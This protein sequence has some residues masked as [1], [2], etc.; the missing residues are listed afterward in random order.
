MAFF[1]NGKGALEGGMSSSRAKFPAGHA[2]RSLVF[3][4]FCASDT[5]FTMYSQLQKKYVYAL[6][7]YVKDIVERAITRNNI[8]ASCPRIIEKYLSNDNVSRPVYLV[9]RANKYLSIFSKQ[10][11][12][13]S[14]EMMRLTASSWLR[15]NF[16]DKRDYAVLRFSYLTR[17]TETHE[18]ESESCTNPAYNILVTQQVLGT[19][20]WFSHK[21]VASNF[22]SSFGILSYCSKALVNGRVEAEQVFRRP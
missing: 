4:R 12:K 18:Y 20:E 17:V 6:S 14:Q 7:R 22:S 9:H 19:R 15:A 10:Y 3:E 1:A 21:N 11:F 16:N 13:L 8:A 5:S 2:C